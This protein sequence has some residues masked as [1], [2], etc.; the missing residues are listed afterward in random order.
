M[1]MATTGRQLRGVLAV[2]REDVQAVL[3]RDP[4]AQDWVDVLIGSPALYAIWLHRTAHHL[5]RRRVT[6]AA[7]LLSTFNRFLTGVDI[8]PGAKLGRR[9]VIDHGM[10]VVI[11]ETASIGD[12]CLLYQGVA[13]GAVTGERIDRH[14]E[15]EAGVVVGA[16]ACV[17]GRIRVGRGAKIGAGSVVT[18]SVPPG[19]TVVGI[20]GR[21]VVKDRADDDSQI[22]RRRRAG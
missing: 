1:K 18:A 2:A 14:P 8:H 11:G 4:A 20:P 22:A 17:L 16:N 21:L 5:W 7:R 19:V 12:D 15:L 9:V 13:L 3:A 6:R 10:G